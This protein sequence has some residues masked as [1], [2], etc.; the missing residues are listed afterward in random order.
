MEYAVEG[1]QGQIQP[2]CPRHP[3]CR[4]AGPEALALCPQP[5]LL[6]D[7]PPPCAFVAGRADHQEIGVG[8][9][10]A[11]VEDDDLISPLSG[12]SQVSQRRRANAGRPGHSRVDALLLDEPGYGLGDEV[13]QRLVGRR[14]RAPAQRRR[15]RRTAASPASSPGPRRQGCA[16]PPR[17]RRRRLRPAGRSPAAPTRPPAPPQPAP[18]GHGCVRP[19]TN[20]SSRVRL[21]ALQAAPTSHTYSTWPLGARP[22]GW[23]R[24]IARR[25]PRRAGSS[26]AA[27]RAL[28]IDDP[29]VRGLATRN[30]DHLA[31]I[32]AC[33]SASW[34]S[35]RWPRCGRVERRAEDPDAGGGATH[36]VGRRRAPGT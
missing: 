18:P 26:P 6:D 25:R 34:A 8:N 7:R 32:G 4:P 36:A 5:Y 13:A 1:S 11:H 31:Q 12:V 9:E 23:R 30:Q 15:R 17:P 16:A 10:V 27:A 2:A 22:P 3:R 21:A 28:V 19:I 14:R 35:A 29:L 33:Q 20:T 24:R